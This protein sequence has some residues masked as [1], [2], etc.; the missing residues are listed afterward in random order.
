[1]RSPLKSICALAFC[2]L[3]PALTGCG[4]FFTYPGSSTTTGSTTTSYAYFANSTTDTVSGYALASGTPVAVTG[5]PY[6]K[7]AVSPTSLVVTP[8]NTF[9]Y[10]GGLG[11][12]YG[13]SIDTTTGALTILNSG[14][15]FAAVNAVSM[16]VSP[17][18]NWLLVLDVN[19]V[20][21]DEYAINTSTGALTPATGA[22][23]ST[24]GAGASSPHAIRFAPS[25]TLAFAALGTG[26][27]AVFTFTTSTGALVQSQSLAGSATTSDNAVAIDSTSS[28]LYIARSGTG[29]GINA[30]TIGSAGALNG[31]TGSPFAT[32]NGPYDVVIDKTGAYL[33]A[34]NRT[35]GT[36]SGFTIATTGTLT[37]LSGSPFAS[38][39]LVTSLGRD[40]LGKYIVAASQG[41]SSDLT[42]YSFDT[43]TL[44]KLDVA[45]TATTGTDPTGAIAVAMTH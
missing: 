20:F 25:G 11:A 7:L 13:Y 36:V 27:D 18:G 24:T 38:G 44:G 23:Y 37:A 35:D 15:A 31:I 9:L 32:G 10:V 43:T 1:M 12:L 28:H 33:Y 30:Y 14:Q 2:A 8:A 6:A 21:V 4:T 34:A 22:G 29:T 16:D 5:S 42:M 19:G 41:G 17:D 26:G 39:S 3:I 40:S 45:A